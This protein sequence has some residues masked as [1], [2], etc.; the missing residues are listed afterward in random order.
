MAEPGDPFRVPLDALAFRG[1]SLKRPESVLATAK[2]DLFACDWR[3]A[4]CRIAADGRE[5]VI[6]AP[7]LVERG[8]KAN[9]IAIR[10]DGSFLFANVGEAGGIWSLSGGGALAPFLR[11][12]DGVALPSTNFV[13]I[14]DQD[15]IW[16]CVSTRDPASHAPSHRFATSGGDGIIAVMDRSG[17]RIVAEGLGW[18][19][20]CRID[21]TG[22][23]LYVN[24]TFG[25]RLT[26][27]RIAPDASLS[28]RE[29]VT[30]FGPGAWPD[31]MAFDREGGLWITS[32][33]SNR[34][35]R[36]APDGTETIVLEDN[37][38]AEVDRVEAIYRAGGLTREVIFGVAPRR[39]A[40][41]ASLAFGG[42]DLRTIH[43]GSLGG[44]SI[45]FF[46][47]PVAGL[48][49]SHWSVRVPGA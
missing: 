10:R 3:G 30:E 21:P 42:P 36:L 5:T 29:T 41:I 46:R 12:V 23:F 26:R 22:A 35:I 13:W 18:T 11:E 14:D 1:A 48:P 32:I 43:L 24:E 20:E 34:L 9:G 27:F 16:I 33:I 25:R 40:N 8:V 19:N 31:G 15:R 39:L 28:E 4:I 49:P 47:S 2:G 38:P 44:S 6:G 17:V 7:D 45:P 37:D